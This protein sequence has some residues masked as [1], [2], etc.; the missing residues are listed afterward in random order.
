MKIALLVGLGSFTGGI[1]RYMLSTWIHAKFY[2][3]FPFGTLVV[4]VAGCFLIGLVFGLAERGQI[5]PEARLVV[6][7]GILGG[8]TTF[9]AFS[10]ET[11][12]L[13]R[14]G[15]YG[16]ALGYVAASVVLG[17]LGTWLGYEVV[18]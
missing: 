3:V 5:A 13:L 9:S 17:V 1:L 2:S 4:N 12:G 14:E 15:A 8:F 16:M 11:L 7:T 6:A 18:R 10:N